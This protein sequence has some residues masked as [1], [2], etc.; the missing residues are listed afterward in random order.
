MDFGLQVGFK[1][2]GTGVV[3]FQVASNGRP[4]SSQEPQEWP[5]SVPRASQESPKSVP[6]ASESAPRAP[7]ECPRA[8][9]G[10]P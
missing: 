9:Q 4:R 3:F 6:R 8:S 1:K 2:K 7:Q 5:E 10:R